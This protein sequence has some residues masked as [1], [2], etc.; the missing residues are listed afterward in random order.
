MDDD[1]CKIFNR[2]LS[3]AGPISSEAANP[4][5]A[6]LLWPN[7]K[8]VSY[9][10][11]HH[12]LRD[13]S[14]RAGCPHIR[15]HQLRHTFATALLRAGFSLSALKDVLG[16]RDIRMTLG[17][18]QV[19]Q[20]DLQREYHQARQKMASV[21]TVPQPANT[22]SI[23]TPDDGLPTICRTV[24]A[25]RHQL[26]MYRRHLN[27]QRGSRK[28]LSLLRRLAKLRTALVDLQKA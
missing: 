2:I 21:H 3:L 13:A 19:T 8:R 27:N 16:H 5:S 25:L 24:D 20:N 6:L 15:P 11:I 10:R 22:L 14:Q 4:M 12:A 9:H 1:G 7:G 26:E 18:V 23:E 28:L 17:Y